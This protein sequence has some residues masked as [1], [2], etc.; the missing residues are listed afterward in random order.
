MHIKIFIQY[1]SVNEVNHEESSNAFAKLALLPPIT[2]TDIVKTLEGSLGL[3]EPDLPRA[4]HNNIVL[5]G[6]RIALDQDLDVAVVVE[7]NV[8]RDNNNTIL[9]DEIK[10]NIMYFFQMFL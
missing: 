4:D 6:V 10:K 8:R 9:I 2:I 5:A 1:S 7:A 3:C